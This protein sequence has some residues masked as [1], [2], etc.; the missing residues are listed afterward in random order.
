MMRMRRLWRWLGSATVLTALGFIVLARLN[1][2]NNLGE[3]RLAQQAIAR[4]QLAA[5]RGRLAALAVRPGSLG[6]AAAYWL[7]ISESLAGNPEA[8]LEAF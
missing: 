8:A 6:G 2:W 3:L 7:G 5:A 4:G 1:A